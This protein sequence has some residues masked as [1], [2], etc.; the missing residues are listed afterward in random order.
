M[1]RPDKPINVLLYE[2]KPEY[3]GSFKTT[4]Q[5]QRIIV[6]VVDNGDE[7]LEILKDNPRK[8]Q[9]VVL[10]ARAF[11]HEGQQPGT[12]DEMNLLPIIRDLDKLRQEQ[13][14]TLPYCIN[15]GFAD[16]KLRLANK[17]LCPIFEKGNETD[18]INHIWAEYM[19]TDDAKLLMSHPEIFGFAVDHFDVTSYAVLSGLFKNEQHL[20]SGI[21]G[22]VNNLSALRRI[23][24]HLMDLVHEKYLNNSVQIG[25]PSSR[26]REIT[27]YL[28]DKNDLPV[29]VSSTIISVRKI[30]SNFGSHT[31]SKPEEIEAYPSGELIGGLASSLKDVFIWAKRIF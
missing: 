28:I 3:A 21:A 8:Y 5:K 22:R 2:D 6:K 30:A 7:L 12:E 15:T 13:Q 10:D 23:A 20:A 16:L 11:M 14:I 27:Q 25:S 31:P 24:E 19:K 17:V 29:H 1:I 4:A 18:L 26:L 9:F